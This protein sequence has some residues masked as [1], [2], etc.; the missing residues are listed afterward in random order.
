MIF[1]SLTTPPS[2]LIGVDARSSGDKNSFIRSANRFHV[3]TQRSRHSGNS[4]GWARAGWLPP[5]RALWKPLMLDQIARPHVVLLIGSAPDA[6]RCKAWP[7]S[8]FR[9]IVAINNAWRVR[10]DWDVLVH[11]GDF[12]RDRLPPSDSLRKQI[13]TSSDYVAAQNRF[14][15]FVYAGP[16]MAFTAAYW[17]LDTLRP[18]VLLFLGC[19]MT[20]DL[21]E[22]R[23]HFYGNGT[24]DPL[25]NDKTLK[26]LEAKSARLFVCALQQGTLCLN[27]SDKVASR[28]HLPR[29]P[30]TSIVALDRMTVHCWGKSFAAKVD[31]TAAASAAENERN[32]GYFVPDGRYWLHLDRFDDTA[33]EVVDRLWF[34]AVEGVSLHNLSK[35]AGDAANPV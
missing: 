31:L 28:L 21:V 14:G 1:C 6:V 33:L 17:V 34:A 11:S 30:E 19:D 12:P 35:G 29:L 4:W 20:Y 9:E 32:L 24:A 26:N 22:G 5:A 25:R 13:V 10:D 7:K 23:T 15:G 16:T 3:S 2:D 27:L 8:L 18:D